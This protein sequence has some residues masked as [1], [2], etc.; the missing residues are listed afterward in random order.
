PLYGAAVG[1]FYASPFTEADTTQQYSEELR[2]ASSGAGPLQ[3]IAGAFFS[4]FKSIFAEH[5]ASVPL[6]STIPGQLAVN[7]DGIL[8]QALNPYRIKEYAV[9]GEGT[10][11]LAD[12]WK[13]TA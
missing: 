7:P 10:Y 8:Y 3:W 2:L 9:F 13:V 1:A 12:N 11:A 4:D 6:I 5:N